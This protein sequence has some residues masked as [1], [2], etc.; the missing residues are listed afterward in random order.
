MLKGFLWK[1]VFMIARYGRF[2]LLVVGSMLLLLLSACNTSMGGANSPSSSGGTGSSGNNGTS[3][4]KTPMQVLKSS[5]AAMKQLKT[6]HFNMD[7]VTTMNNASTTT[8]A[9]HGTTIMLQDSGDQ[10]FPNQLTMHLN[11]GQATGSPALTLSEVVVG[12]KVY[13]QSPKG[14]WFTL[15]DNILKS[16][17]GNPLAGAN[18]ANYNNLLTLAQKESLSDHGTENMSGQSLRHITVHFSSNVLRDLLATT[19][20]LNSMSAQQQEALKNTRLENPTLD[21]WIDEATSYVHRMVLK[22]TMSAGTSAI[23]TAVTTK[24]SSSPVMSSR[25]ST[26]VNTAID[27]SKF[28]APVKITAPSNAISTSNISQIFE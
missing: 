3:S 23:G 26:D 18:V 9:P 21:L 4:N 1:G 24:S 11:V 12:Q 8:A 28:N 17:T 10:Q 5:D 7:S 25:T 20:Q 19:G 27:Y 14:K 2:G 16:T 13:I 6:A 15:D 22:F